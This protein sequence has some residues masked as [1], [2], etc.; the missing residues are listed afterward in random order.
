[1][2]AGDDEITDEGANE[3]D[4]ALTAGAENPREPLWA[5]SGDEQKPKT[6]KTARERCCIDIVVILSNGI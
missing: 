3:A 6:T 4:G 2:G 5:K 1:M